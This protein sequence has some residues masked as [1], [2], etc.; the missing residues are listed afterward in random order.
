MVPS[1]SRVW[2]RYSPD[3][4]PLHSGERVGVRVDKDVETILRLLI[5]GETGRT[6]LLLAKNQRIGGDR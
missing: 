5:N 3:I 2:E 4:P 6:V 1:P